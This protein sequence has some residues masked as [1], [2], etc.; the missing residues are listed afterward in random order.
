MRKILVTLSIAAILFSLV[1]P[2]KAHAE[3]GS[4]T[5]KTIELDTVN[6]IRFGDLRWGERAWVIFPKRKIGRRENR[7]QEFDYDAFL[8][9]YVI[10]ESKDAS[11]FGC[12]WNSKSMKLRFC[13][14]RL[15]AANIWFE[16]EWTHP[17]LRKYLVKRFG[18]PK[19]KSRM[20]DGY[21][22]V[23]IVTPLEIELLNWAGHTILKVKHLGFER[24]CH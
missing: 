6:E 8:H 16:K 3:E 12:I 21:K 24:H 18:I 7:I 10:P 22:E 23:W 9:F 11:A 20:A 17:Y 2:K 14:G 13:L 15:F 1:S 4:E 5:V 19:E